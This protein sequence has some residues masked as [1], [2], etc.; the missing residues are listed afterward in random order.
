[1]SWFVYGYTEE[2]GHHFSPPVDQ[3]FRKEAYRIL[4]CDIYR[5]IPDDTP[6]VGHFPAHGRWLVLAKRAG[7]SDVH[8][9]FLTEQQYHRFEFSPYRLIRKEIPNAPVSDVGPPLSSEGST[10]PLPVSPDAANDE[11][12]DICA[13]LFE[14][15]D[16]VVRQRPHR[17]VSSKEATEAHAL[18]RLDEGA[19]R[20]ELDSLTADE[21]TAPKA[22][23][24]KA[25]PQPERLAPILAQLERVGSGVE[26]VETA[27]REI[28]GFFKEALAQLDR[29]IDGLQPA[30][31]APDRP[32]GGQLAEVTESLERISARLDRIAQPVDE[33]RNDREPERPRPG[34]GSVTPN[35]R[36]ATGA[37]RRAFTM[38]IVAALFFFLGVGVAELGM[39]R[40]DERKAIF[41]EVRELIGKLER[42]AEARF[43]EAATARSGLGER[44]DALGEPVGELSGKTVA[45]ESQMTKQFGDLERFLVK[46]FEEAESARS[47]LDER[48]DALDRSD[49]IKLRATAGELSEIKKLLPTAPPI[50]QLNVKPPSGGGSVP[51]EQ[52]GNG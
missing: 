16:E 14:G 8:G 52:G 36:K 41:D 21:A 34:S 32:Q 12:I 51:S 29:R 49:Q 5:S 27:T 2:D 24:R 31:P 4:H 42:S 47:G 9:R 46:R 15:F 17:S 37:V 10:F 11:Y 7:E 1:M 50:P 19:G 39:G 23:G 6:F 40:G 3:Q 26:N 33:A 45:L 13:R 28:A 38:A 43:R 22:P 48:I 35:R 20:A 18:F 25:E 30:S 44:I